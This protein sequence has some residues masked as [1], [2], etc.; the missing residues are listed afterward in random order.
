[1]RRRYLLSSTLL[2]QMFAKGGEDGPEYK[3]S[4]RLV[5]AWEF[6]KVAR[7]AAGLGHHVIAVST[8]LRSALQSCIQASPPDG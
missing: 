4:H 1:M 2:C 6:S 8:R 3:R 5:N 7:Q